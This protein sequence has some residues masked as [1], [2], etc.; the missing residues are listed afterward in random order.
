MTGFITGEEDL[1]DET[2]LSFTLTKD[3]A[4]TVTDPADKKL[5]RGT[6]TITPKYTGTFS[7]YKL[8]AANIITTNFTVTPQALTGLTVEGLTSKKYNGV[9]NKPT[10]V[11]VK[12]DGV[13]VAAEFDVKYYSDAARTSEATVQDV[14][15]YYVKITSKDDQDYSFTIDDQ[16]Y[17]ITEATLIVT[18]IAKKEYDGNNNLPSAVVVAEPAADANNYLYYRIQGFVDGKNASHVAIGDGSG[19]TVAPTLTNT[20]PTAGTVGNT[21]KLNVTNATASTSVPTPSFT[22]DNYVFSANPGSFVITQKKVKVTATSYPSR[23]YGSTDDFAFTLTSGY[24]SGDADAIKYVTKVVKGDEADDEGKYTLTPAFLTESE[25]DAKVDADDAIAAADKAASKATY[26]AVLTNY[27]L[28]PVAG[29]LKYANAELQIALD[30]SKFTLTK[31]YDGEAISLTAPTAED[32]L[33]IIGR[34]NDSDVIDLSGLTLAITPKTNGNEA[35]TAQGTYQ[36]VL[37]GATAEHYDISYIPSQFTITKRPLKVTAYDQTFVKGQVQ[38]LNTT[39]YSIEEKDGEGLADG[40]TAEEVFKLTTT[41]TFDADGKVTS[42]ADGTINVVD[43][44]GTASKYGNYAVTEVAGVAKLV[45]SAIVLDDS[46][47]SLVDLAGKTADETTAVTFSS[48]TLYAEKWNTLVLPFEV[49][50]KDLSDAFGYA[51]VDV[52][53]Q[54]QSDGN[55]HFI[56]KVTG[57]IAANTPFMIY[58]SDTYNNLNQVTAFN[59]VT[60]KKDAMKNTTVSV[61]D[62]SNNKLVGTYAQ[63]EIGGAGFYYM[64]ANGGWNGLGNTTAKAPIKPLRAYIDMSENTTSSAPIIYI[65]EPNGNTTAIKTLDAETM[66]TYSTDGWYNLNGVKLNGVPTEKGIYINNGKKVVIK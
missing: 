46:K 56:L 16:T 28:D 40:D 10:N 55:L 50:V 41:I 35:L 27:E 26:K 20:A 66:Q 53:D 12:K 31:V 29:S 3:G 33:L 6:Y 49:T 13:A 18:P 30:E 14:A 2:K 7:N 21:Y 64:D 63:T 34:V 48:R 51:V 25:I 47:T 43:V 54:S 15:T 61:K 8:E 58:P 5:G 11:V 39:L 17:D 1:F 22:L 60:I 4:G 9:V 19:G 45:S 42:T 52:L 24:V 38:T 59:S 37:S 44:G 23:A 36:I 65:E 32:K 62:G 57:K